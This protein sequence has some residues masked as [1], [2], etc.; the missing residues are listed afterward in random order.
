MADFHQSPYIATL[1][2]LNDA[3][4]EKMEAELSEFSAKRSLGLVLPSLYSE[5]EGDA[6]TGI[7]DELSQVP[8]LSQI[9]IG[10]DRA[11]RSEYTKAVKFFRRLPQNHRVLWHDGPRLRAI[12]S[13]LAELG[14]APTEFGKGRNVWYCMGYVLATAK[15]DAIALHDCDITT[16]DRILLARLIYPVAHP[17]FSFEFCKGYYA[18]VADQRLN[19]R[20][21]RLLVGPLIHATKRVVGDNEFLSYLESFRYLL[22]GEFAFRRDLLTDMRVPSD[23]GLEMGVASEMY[24]NNS[25]NRI[26]QVEIADFYDHKHQELSV[27]DA[28]RGLSRMSLDITKSLIRKL[29]IQGVVFNQETFRTLKATYYRIALDYVESY[30]RDAIMNG[31]AFDTHLE[32]QAVELFATNV[33][34]AGRQ[35]LERPMDAPFMPTWARVVSAMP[36]IFERLK[37]AVEEDHAEFVAELD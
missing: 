35:Y 19:G 33:M 25:T 18:R 2:N 20:A 4:I 21:C 17:L 23:W 29:A 5:L 37:S 27:E 9:V 8:Y 26:C 1:H 34:E 14:L 15:A 32:E 7:V 30:R 24:R 13:D 22:A 6:L 16:Y 28:S 10:L 31:L 36:D 12:D 11:D 3:P